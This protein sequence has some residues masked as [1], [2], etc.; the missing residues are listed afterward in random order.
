MKYK[1]Y[2]GI[3]LGDR[4]RYV[5]SVDNASKLAKWQ[6]GEAAKPM[7]LTGAKDLIYGLRCNCFNAVIITMP[8]YEKPCNPGKED[9]FGRV[10]WCEEDIR[11]ALENDGYEP[12][13]EAI[14]L[15]R[16]DCENHCFT[17]RAI[18]DGWHHIYCYI[19]EHAKKGELKELETI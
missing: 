9:W 13:E 8:D 14:T 6:D 7:T 4:I 2:V 3:L 18:E 11:T 5:T 16:Q 19:N 15:I 10:Q 17:D 12:T 1:Y